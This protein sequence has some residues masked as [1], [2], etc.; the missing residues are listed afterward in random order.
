M[1]TIL[2][3]T[4]EVVRQV[5]IL[6]APVVPASARKLLAL[7][8]QGDDAQ[9]FKALGEPGRLKPGTP[10]PE[11]TGVFPRYIDDA[12]APGSDAAAPK[13]ATAKDAKAKPAKTK[14]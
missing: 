9:T 5:A 10:L 4:A 13:K 1:E 3:V 2:Y 7:L 6:A 14:P 11:P 12:E 8:G